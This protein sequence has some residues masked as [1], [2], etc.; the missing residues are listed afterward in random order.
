MNFFEDMES[1]AS[2]AE[3]FYVVAEHLLEKFVTISPAPPSIPT[4]TFTAFV[5]KTLSSFIYT[6]NA[7]T[8]E[9]CGI[10]TLFPSVR[11]IGSESSGKQL[12]LGRKSLLAVA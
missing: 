4:H 2:N 9:S 1:A 10:A 6:Q 11:F 5:S 7:S 8:P 12:Q 3:Y